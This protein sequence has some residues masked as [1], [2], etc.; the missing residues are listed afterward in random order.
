VKEVR[1]DLIVA[2]GDSH[3]RALSY[4]STILPFFI[5]PGSFMNNLTKINHKNFHNKL[6]ELINKCEKNTNILLLLNGDVIHHALLNSFDTWNENPIK[7]INPLLKAANLYCETISEASKCINGRIFVSSSSPGH[8][9]EFVECTKKYNAIIQK[10]CIETNCSTYLNLIPILSN[11]GFFKDEYS[12]DFAHT[13]PRSAYLFFELLKQHGALSKDCIYKDFE[14]KHLYKIK[15]KYGE[16]KIWGDF[17]KDRLILDK[18]TTFYWTKYHK[19]TELK[20]NTLNEIISLSSCFFAD[21]KTKPSIVFL[22]SKE[23]FL[24]FNCCNQTF[25]RIIGVEKSDV[26]LKFAKYIKNFFEESKAE[27]FNE[28]EYLKFQYADIIVDIDMIFGSMDYRRRTFIDANKKCLIYYR[29]SIEKET[30]IR[31]LK[32]SGFSHVFHIP[33]YE[34]KR[35]DFSDNFLLCAI[36]F[37]PNQNFK[38]IIDL[39]VKKY[40][41]DIIKNTTSSLKNYYANYSN[42]K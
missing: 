10:F 26:S 22:N 35:S 3:V 13:N 4:C 9:T 8:T 42:S 27:F 15:S 33:F 7:E 23:G 29:L 16:Y 37:I 25:S 38:N 34:T 1:R 6:L 2:V 30:D 31:L 19:E 18:D 20:I 21:F 36:N 17:P 12:G 11:E 14:F 39:R 5:G 24:P 40:I 41:K 28:E 32:K